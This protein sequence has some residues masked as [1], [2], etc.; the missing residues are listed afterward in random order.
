M[1]EEIPAY[2]A[3]AL[4]GLGALPDTILTRSVVIRMRRRAPGEV[5]E[6]YRRRVNL[7]EAEAIRA[8]L[9]SWA[10]SIEAQIT[11]V[12]PDMPETIVDRDADVWEALIAV[13]DAAG[14]DWPGKARVAAVTLVSQSKD[15]TPSLGIQLLKD[16]QTVFLGFEQLSTDKILDALHDIDE[17]PWHDLRGKSLDARGLARYLKP[18]GVHRTTIR[19][20]D[21][22]AK[23]YRRE[24]LHDPWQRY[25]SGFPSPERVTEVTEGTE[26]AKVTPVTHVTHLPEGNPE[27]YQNAKDPEY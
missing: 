20:G 21:R 12:F 22:T 3:V 24:D 8:R 10:S 11:G 6:P 27:S 4:A 25:L 15:D 9:E 19:I 17:S 1:T 7:P 13:A 18:Y 14:G 23:G 2:C 5:V 16:L 26:Q